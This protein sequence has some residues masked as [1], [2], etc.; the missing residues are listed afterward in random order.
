MLM[1]LLKIRRRCQFS[2][3]LWSPFL[4]VALLRG[5]VIINVI[6]IIIIN[7]IYITIIIIIINII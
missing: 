5:I 6:I 7:F 4:V 1:S 2:L 3:L